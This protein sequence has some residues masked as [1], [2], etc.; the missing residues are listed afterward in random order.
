MTNQ[1]IKIDISEEDARQ[2]SIGNSFDWTYVTDKGESIDIHLYGTS[3]EVKIECD[4]CWEEIKEEDVIETAEMSI[5]CPD[6]VERESL[7]TT[8]DENGK[9]NK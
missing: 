9:I 3:N 5:A 8:A 4:Y 1:K 7:M 6:C 2:L